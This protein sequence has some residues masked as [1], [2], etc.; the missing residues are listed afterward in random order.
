MLIL[1]RKIH[2]AC[3]IS[4]PSPRNTAITGLPPSSLAGSHGSEDSLLQAFAY[5][6]AVMYPV[7]LS[8]LPPPL[9]APHGTS[10][11]AVHAS[12]LRTSVFHPPKGIPFKQGPSVLCIVNPPVFSSSKSPA[13]TF[14][15][16]VVVLNISFIF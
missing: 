2:N 9:S 11:P 12:L 10:R 8:P 7:K 5:A 13:I 4:I 6:S 16:W 15:L 14:S 3:A 1:K